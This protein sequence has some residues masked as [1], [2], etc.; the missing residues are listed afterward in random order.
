MERRKWASK[1]MTTGNI[2]MSKCLQVMTGTSLLMESFQI[3][4]SKIQSYSLDRSLPSPMKSTVLLILHAQE[5]LLNKTWR[6]SNSVLLSSQ[7]WQLE[8]TL[9]DTKVPEKMFLIFNAFQLKWGNFFGHMVVLI[10]DRTS[11][12][13]DID[14]TK[15]GIVSSFPSKLWHRSDRLGRWTGVC[16]INWGVPQSLSHILVSQFCYNL[17]IEK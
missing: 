12:I 6:P 2:G 5:F 13:P 9:L 15:T 7:K 10:F 8:H 16:H 14:C 11:T 3:C 1:T 4:V 17:E